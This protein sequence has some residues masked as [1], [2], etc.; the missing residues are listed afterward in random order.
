MQKPF[1]TEDALPF[2]PLSDVGEFAPITV[3]EDITPEAVV[4]TDGT[5]FADAML[6]TIKWVFLF[7]PGAA[8]IHF[9]MM[10]L[11]LFVFYK[12]WFPEPLMGAVVGA[13]IATFMVMFGVGKLGDL[14]YLKVA[15]TIFGAATLAG[16]CYNLSILFVPGDFFGWFC[17][18][19]L[20]ITILLAQ[21]VKLKI[22]RDGGAS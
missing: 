15:G 13:I 4:L 10:G 18:L 19:T 2:C 21:I 14:K 3:R 11:S 20:P 5:H 9:L 1:K 6:A 17:L 7:L 12:D 22:D 8:A 16:I